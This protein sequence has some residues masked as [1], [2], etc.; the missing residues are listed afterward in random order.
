[1]TA[2]MLAAAAATTAASIATHAALATNPAAV[3][4]LLALRLPV[5]ESLALATW[6]G[7]AE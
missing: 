1:M 6:M 7:S 2:F 3:P 5:P 4:S